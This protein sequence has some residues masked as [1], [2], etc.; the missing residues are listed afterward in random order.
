MSGIVETL[1]V[2]APG[3]SSE[4]LRVQVL[5]PPGYRADAAVGYPVLYLN[6]GQDLEAVALPSAL[7]Q[8]V[9]EAAIDPPI[10]VAI[11]MPADRL[12]AY[13]LSDRG[14]RHGL[15][16]QTRFG[17]V[18]AAAHAYSEW[19]ANVLVPMIDAAYR[20]RTTPEARTALGWSLGAVH[21]LNLGWQ[22]PELFARVGAF[23]P[24]LWLAADRDAVQRT[25]LAQR[26]LDSSQPRQGLKV[27]VGVG[28]SEET[29][30]RDGDGVNDALDDARDLVDGWRDA[31]GDL[32]GLRQLGFSVNL[33]YA[34][35]AT[36]DDIALYLLR[37][38]RHHQSS[39]AQMLPVFLRWAYARRSPALAATGSVDR[40]Q[41]F[42]PAHVPSR[43]VDDGWTP[44]HC[45][46]TQLRLPVAACAPGR[47]SCPASLSGSSRLARCRSD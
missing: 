22:Y 32:K 20:T 43:N 9:A 46:D 23:S 21:A 29:D 11:E 37:D 19:I 40:Y 14:A 2:P 38:G 13:G 1:H 35:G 45:D 7:A 3:A 27:F 30:D 17:P 39:W 10:V 24:S 4:P 36:C 25:R 6:D 31:G 5:L 33:D 47:A 42:A 15:V 41:E 26:M 34:G 12:A 44:G 28:D 16:A 18:G 8:L